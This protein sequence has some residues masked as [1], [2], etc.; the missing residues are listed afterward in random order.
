MSTKNRALVISA[1]GIR[2]VY[3]IAAI[4]RDVELSND[5]EIRWKHV[6]GT[7][8]GAILA[9]FLAM[10]PVGEERRAVAEMRQLLT[11]LAGDNGLR[12]FLP[13]GLAQGLLWHRG[14][15][16]PK[17]LEEM[18]QKHIDPARIRDSGRH[19]HIFTVNTSNGQR[20][21]VT[22]RD[23]ELIREYLMASCSIPLVFPPKEIKDDRSPS[24]KSYFSDGG[25]TDFV[26]LRSALENPEIDHVDVIVSVGDAA[27]RVVSFA[28]PGQY[29]SLE[30]MVNI[31]LEGFYRMATEETESMIDKTNSMILLKL[32]ISENPKAIEMMPVSERKKLRETLRQTKREKFVTSRIYRP[33]QPLSLTATGYKESVSTSLWDSGLQSVDIIL[34]DEKTEHF[35]HILYF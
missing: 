5:D 30:N 4:F 25:T 2:L 26:P 33:K 19:L 23:W 12:N 1:S 28:P 22:E 21:E 29:P 14:L 18:I 3:E 8:G 15:Y 20:K 24:G 9:T 13:F 16:S 35:S 17:F 34:T 6:Y 32:L 11:Q 31:L 7:S 27:N 10:Y